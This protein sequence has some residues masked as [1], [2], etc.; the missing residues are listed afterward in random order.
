M[1]SDMKG[2]VPFKAELEEGHMLA[3]G[4]RGYVGH[5]LPRDK[6]GLQTG[7]HNRANAAIKTTTNRQYLTVPRSVQK[8]LAKDQSAHDRFMRASESG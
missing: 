6:V 8:C 3:E 4:E 1:F 7:S 2:T 5:E